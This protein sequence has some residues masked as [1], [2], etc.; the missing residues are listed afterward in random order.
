M[1]IHY[2]L[3]CRF[4]L[5]DKFSRAAPSGRTRLEP[6]CESANKCW[7]KCLRIDST[8]TTTSDAIALELQSWEAGYVGQWSIS[9]QIAE[10]S[11]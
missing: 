8:C 3:T 4:R 2:Q 7:F 9:D 6:Y 1:S 11:L 5:A 10:S